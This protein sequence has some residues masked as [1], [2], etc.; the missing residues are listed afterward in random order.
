MEFRLIVPTSD[1]L[2]LAATERSANGFAASIG[3]ATVPL[4]ACCSDLAALVIVAA[5]DNDT[6]GTLRITGKAKR[7]MGYCNA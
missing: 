4:L 5:G 3:E 6:I 1:S 2:Q 7:D